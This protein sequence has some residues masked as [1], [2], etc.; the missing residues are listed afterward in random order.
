M[1]THRFKLLRNAISLLFVVALITPILSGKAV[2]VV[3]SM[4]VN[5][6]Y[7]IVV[8]A[9]MQPRDFGGRDSMLNEAREYAEQ[10]TRISPSSPRAHLVEGRIL[11]LQGEA[12]VSASSFA[13]AVA[14]G[15][16]DD[17]ARLLYGNALAQ[18][19]KYQE[20]IGQWAQ[21]QMIARWH[22]NLAEDLVLRQEYSSAEK[23]YRIAID[24]AHAQPNRAEEALG[25]RG[26][27]DL[28]RTGRKL[29]LV[30]SYYQK[31]VELAPY[32]P[33]TRAGL[34]HALLDME[35][36]TEAREEANISLKQQP[37]WLAHLVLGTIFLREGELEQA[38]TSFEASARLNPADTW[39]R[40]YLG[41]IRAKQGDRQ[42]AIDLW[43]EVIELHP[44]FAPAQQALD[45][46]SS[47]DSK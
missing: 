11:L 37:N 43:R 45:E 15:A 41:Y 32:D 3:A 2:H 18:A 36:F 28:A 27:G 39:G 6:A 23:E 25:Y 34:A 22:R 35:R 21:G 13:S 12:V 14:L 44:G 47:S 7:L 20:A 5:R 42:A 9:L 16:T 1:K 46:L 31:A 26:L 30:V 17:I 24:V 8:Q 33:L 40:Y 29:D 10:S 4:K 19:G 38:A